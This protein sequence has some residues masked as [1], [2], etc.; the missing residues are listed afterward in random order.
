MLGVVLRELEGSSPGLQD[1]PAA[2]VHEV[3]KGWIIVGRV[4]RVL[5]LSKYYSSQGN[6]TLETPMF[7]ASSGM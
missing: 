5:V 4:P 3:S 6:R 2:E 7:H 1:V